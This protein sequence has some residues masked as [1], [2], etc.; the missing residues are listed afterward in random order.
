MA[1]EPGVPVL[2]EVSQTSTT[3]VLLQQ[4]FP[5]LPKKDNQLLF[6]YRIS[7]NSD[8][9]PTFYNLVRFC[10][11]A[12]IPVMN[13]VITLLLAILFAVNTVAAFTIQP[14]ALARAQPV[15]P[16]TPFSSTSLHLKIKVDPEA[17]KSNRV[18]PA[19]FKNAAYGGSIALA[20]ILP[21]AFIIWA[22]FK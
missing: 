9:V 20:V 4:L 19:V 5:F 3:S 2:L 17:E 12:S 21:L 8:I 1:S 18:N 14:V 15:A 13:R 22:A 10:Q 7:F 6:P 16:C 11:H